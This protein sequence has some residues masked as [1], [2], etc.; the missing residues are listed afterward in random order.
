MLGIKLPVLL[1]P[2]LQG[3]QAPTTVYHHFW[4]QAPRRRRKL[5][6]SACALIV[7]SRAV[8]FC[9]AHG[10]LV[11]L[12]LEFLPFSCLRYRAK[13]AGKLSTRLSGSAVY[14]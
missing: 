13:R 12:V 10:F 7:W 9:S 8:D 2:C 4:V 11:L 6:V 1:T 3:L 14:L 5:L